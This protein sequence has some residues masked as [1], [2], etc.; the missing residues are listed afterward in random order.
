MLQI[1][2]QIF[3]LRFWH[4]CICTFCSNWGKRLGFGSIIVHLKVLYRQ[5]RWFAHFHTCTQSVCVCGMKGLCL[6]LI[7]C[8]CDIKAFTAFVPPNG[9]PWTNL[10]QQT[11][12]CSQHCSQF[13]F[14]GSIDSGFL[15][16]AVTSEVNFSF[17][18]S[19]MN[20][21]KLSYVMRWSRSL[22][23]ASSIAHIPSDPTGS[24]SPCSL[25]TINSSSCANF[26]SNKKTITAQNSDEA[27]AL[28][29][30]A[31]LLKF[32]KVQISPILSILLS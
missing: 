10:S 29:F 20:I 23:H 4:S 22:S 30:T 21:K 5:V 9:S 1:Q 6:F 18:G 8:S 12:V 7:R 2:L 15:F 3:L 16:K 26:F 17:G 25:I 27:V 13:I 31:L 28:F 11:R 24:F 14:T 32:L 19:T